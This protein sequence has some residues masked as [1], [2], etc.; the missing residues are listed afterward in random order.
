MCV[1]DKPIKSKSKSGYKVVAIKNG[2]YYSIAMGFCYNQ[3][4]KIPV[5]A[6]QASLTYFTTNILT[7]SYCYVSAMQGRTTIFKN[8]G[9]AIRLYEAIMTDMDYCGNQV[10]NINSYEITIVEA[11]VTDELWE[12]TYGTSV[13]YAGRRISFGK[14]LDAE[15]LVD[16]YYDY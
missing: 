10:S 15:A 9:G 3:Y 2:K 4:E 13:I 6:H 16:E 5:V 8:K 11:T 14:I 1:L 12:G 7:N